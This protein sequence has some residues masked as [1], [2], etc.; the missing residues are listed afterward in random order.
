M[1]FNERHFDALLDDFLDA[2]RDCWV[3]EDTLESCRSKLETLRNTFRK[4]E[5]AALLEAVQQRELAAE[6]LS[7]RAQREHTGL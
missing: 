4:N 7:A 3:A 1:G 5:E 2:M 6:I